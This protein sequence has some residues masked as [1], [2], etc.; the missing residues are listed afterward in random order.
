MKQQYR[1]RI[2]RADGTEY[3]PETFVEWA[4]T[5]ESAMAQAVEGFKAG[6]RGFVSAS[7]T[8]DTITIIT[9]WK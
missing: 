5:P 2:L 4:E 9:D 6:M 1:T 7:V 3:M 8:G